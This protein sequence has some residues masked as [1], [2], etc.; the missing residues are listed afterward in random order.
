MSALSSQADVDRWLAL[1]AP[2]RLVEGLDSHGFRCPRGRACHAILGKPVRYP[3]PRAGR[4]K[5]WATIRVP[6]AVA[7]GLIAAKR[8]A[9]PRE[10]ALVAGQQELPL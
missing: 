1:P 7:S 10:T 4:A 8:R 6:V 3:Q 2:A 5:G 9:G